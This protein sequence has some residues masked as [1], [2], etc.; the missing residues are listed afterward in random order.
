MNC[1]TEKKKG[2]MIQKQ[3]ANTKKIDKQ[4]IGTSRV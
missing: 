2:K 3:E 1:I 4:K